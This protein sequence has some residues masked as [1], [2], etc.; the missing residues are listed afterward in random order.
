MQTELQQVK[1]IMK[2]LQEDKEI[3][4]IRHRKDKSVLM[5]YIMA[6]TDFVRSLKMTNKNLKKDRQERMEIQKKLHEELQTLGVINNKLQKKYETVMA[7]E[8]DMQLELERV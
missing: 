7:I 4:K 8:V 3:A 6:L 1:F 5:K 2:K